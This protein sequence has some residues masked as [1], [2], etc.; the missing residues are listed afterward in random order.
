MPYAL[1]FYTYLLTAG[2][3]MAVV[4]DILAPLGMIATLSFAAT[5]PY[6]AIVI[7]RR[8]L[9]RKNCLT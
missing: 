7:G 5:M 8:V 9:G 2:F 1:R 4:A 3:V 6:V